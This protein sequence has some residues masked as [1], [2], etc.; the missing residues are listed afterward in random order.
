ML[1]NN[2][3][4]LRKLIYRPSQI[5]LVCHRFSDLSWLNSTSGLQLDE[6]IINNLEFNPANYV[7]S[8]RLPCVT[9]FVFGLKTLEFGDKGLEHARLQLD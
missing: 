8:P 6:L 7:L 3:N 9:K 2:K 5:G 4:T 1:A